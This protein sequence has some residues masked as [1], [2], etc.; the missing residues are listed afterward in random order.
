MFGSLLF[1]LACEV[2]L[3]EP[4]TSMQKSSRASVAL[5]SFVPSKNSPSWEP[6]GVCSGVLG[7]PSDS[8]DVQK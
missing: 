7:E 8:V 1:F 2:M 5:C 6:A 4:E 3:M